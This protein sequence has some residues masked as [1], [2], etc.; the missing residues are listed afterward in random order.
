[1]IIFLIYIA[2]F[3]GSFFLVRLIVDQTAKGYSARKTVTFGDESAVTSNR[4][5]SVVS[6]L[7]IFLLWG[8]STLPVPSCFCGPWLQTP[9]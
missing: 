5:A 6:I 9:I 2:I 8:G 4:S 1:M 7:T 3:V